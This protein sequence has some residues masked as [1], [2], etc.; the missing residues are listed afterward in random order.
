M[1]EKKQWIHRNHSI[2][3]CPKPLYN[4]PTALYHCPYKNQLSAARI[5]GTA[6]AMAIRPHAQ[7]T[8]TLCHVSKQHRLHA[9]PTAAGLYAHPRRGG[10]LSCSAP[11]SQQLSHMALSVLS[12]L[13][14]GE[15]HHAL[16]TDARCF[17]RSWSGAERNRV[18][19]KRA[20][21]APL[22]LAGSAGHIVEMK[23]N[24][25]LTSCPSPTSVLQTWVLQL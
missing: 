25:G 16:V 11:P 4:C 13:K 17:S 8:A 19:R 1:K 9:L 21:T 14:A 23:R 22:A 15:R 12:I 2:V 24:G 18:E 10:A 7:K 20:R 6:V 3:T 5:A